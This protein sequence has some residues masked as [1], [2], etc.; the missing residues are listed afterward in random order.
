[1]NAFSAASMMAEAEAKSKLAEVEARA[2][3]AKTVANL[4]ARLKQRKKSQVKQQVAFVELE[5]A[6]I[7]ITILA[8]IFG[9]IS[10]FK[11]LLIIYNN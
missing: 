8:F 7:E 2:N 3:R 5:S 10:D 11:M 6:A 9:V 4:Q 1:M